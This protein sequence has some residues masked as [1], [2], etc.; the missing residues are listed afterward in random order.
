MKLRIGEIAEMQGISNQTLQYYDRIGLLKPIT[1]PDNGYRFYNETHIMKL[2]TILSLKKA[3]M[4]LK[5]IGRYLGSEDT[6]ESVKTLRNQSRKIGGM[7]TELQRLQAQLDRRLSKVALFNRRNAEM[8][9]RDVPELHL[10]EMGVHPRATPLEMER[11]IKRLYLHVK[12]LEHH[13]F[14]QLGVSC[15]RKEIL[16]LKESPAGP[17]REAFPLKTFLIPLSSPYP[18]SPYYTRRAPGTYAFIYH[19]GRYEDTSQSYTRLLAFLIEQ[20]ITITGDSIE[21]P[22]IDALINQ[23]EKAF[24]TEILVP[25]ARGS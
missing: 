7:V 15:R 10:A 2:D 20:G 21:L 22:V 18:E 11:V 5:E 19:Y 16:K 9:I 6:A 24:V 23:N 4:S 14:L 17:K 1:D 8:G 25:V 12:K 13:E 3:G